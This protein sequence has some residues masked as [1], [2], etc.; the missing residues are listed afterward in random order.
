MKTISGN[1]AIE[2]V[3]IKL[4]YKIYRSKRLKP[5][6]IVAKI[7]NYSNFLLP[8]KATA[9]KYTPLPGVGTGNFKE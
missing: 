6:K 5:T 7:E 3:M 1:N 9:E 8:S 4:R 2:S